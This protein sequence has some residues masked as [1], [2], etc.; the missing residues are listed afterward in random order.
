[1]VSP[2][3]ETSTVLRL[4]GWTVYASGVVATIG[5]VFLIAMFASFAVGATPA[6][7]VFGWMN[8]VLVMVS[9]LLA[10]PSAIALGVLLRP[11]AP[12]LSGLAVVI[13]ISAIAA[14]VVLQALLVVGAL[15]FEAQIGPVSIAFLGLVVWFVLTGYL[16][17]SS[18]A[19]PQG[20]RMGLLAATYVGYPLWA[21]WLGRQLIPLAREPASGPGGGA[22]R[23]VAA[24]EG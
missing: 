12:T 20:V 21:F 8:D 22:E 6:G 4:G 9:Y 16:G 15:A 3:T 14:I 18:G 19:L 1:M 5:V 13:G 10:A 7:Q 17:S 23:Y 24:R 2:Q 11:G